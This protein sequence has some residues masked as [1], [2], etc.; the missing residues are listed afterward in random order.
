M[1]STKWE[2]KIEN[3]RQ[4]VRQSYPLVLINHL[5]LYVAHPDVE[6]IYICE[7]HWVLCD[8]NDKKNKDSSKF[9]KSKLKEK[10]IIEKK[11]I[12]RSVN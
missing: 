7:N 3:N 6:L 8:I 10:K 1:N 2:K 5:N 12:D 4:D 9:P 11:D